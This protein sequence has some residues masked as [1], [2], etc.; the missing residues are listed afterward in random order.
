MAQAGKSRKR[1]VLVVGGGVAGA[2]CA[3]SLAQG[4]AK[5]HLIEKEPVIG[6]HGAQMGCKATNV[7]LRCNV[8]VA[9]DLLKEVLGMAAVTVHTRTEL[10][11]LR[12]GVK[13]SRYTAGLNHGANYID[14]GS[15]IGCG[16]CVKVGPAGAIGIPYPALSPKAV[17]VDESAW[18][19]AAA[20]ARARCA[21]ACPAGAINPEAKARTSKVNVDNVVVATGFAAYSPV[22]NNLYGYGSVENVITGLEAERQLGE[23]NKIVRPTDGEAPKRL[24]FIQ[25]VGSRT[26]EVF[27]RPDD[28]DYCSA[29]CCA[30]ALRM[31]RRMKYQAEDCDV[32]VFYMDI[33]N[34]GKGF[35]EF[36]RQCKDEMR[37]VRSRPYRLSAG[38]D[39]SVVVQYAVAEGEREAG[40][41]VRKEEFDMVVLAVGIRPGEQTKELAEK[42]ALASDESGFLGLKGTSSLADVQRE[43]IF[44]AGANE[45]PKDMA[46]S[47][48]QAQAV[49]AAIMSEDL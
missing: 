49:S 32:T 9:Y 37:F 34:F 10:D 33:Q 48:A 11:E 16:Y 14:A 22:E 28:T 23:L 27:R 24:A 15:C 30:Y 12:G 8:C 38:E 18:L 43:G 26:E 42:L 20:E 47:I 5:V 45:S 36:Y 46:G 41:S 13:D 25:C 31:G 40:S 17:V 29:V 2:A 4:G 3:R 35:D 19:G 39:G 44:V 21:A 7:C 1:T 6:G